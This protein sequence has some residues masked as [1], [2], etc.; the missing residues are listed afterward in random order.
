MF[1]QVSACKPHTDRDDYR[2]DVK[3]V[4]QSERPTGKLR[5][6]EVNNE[7]DLCSKYP[8]MDPFFLPWVVKWWCCDS[9]CYLF[10]VSHVYRLRGRPS[11]TRL[12][13][14][15]VPWVPGF[16]SLSLG[17]LVELWVLLNFIEAKCCF[18]KKSHKRNIKIPSFIYI[19]SDIKI[20]SVATCHLWTSRL[21]ESIL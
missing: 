8:F 11:Q 2:A 5:H 3:H 16:R 20:S 12:P 10:K 6:R 14:G 4:K 18:L 17:R 21:F 15:K 19:T 13:C 9:R 7:K 1:L